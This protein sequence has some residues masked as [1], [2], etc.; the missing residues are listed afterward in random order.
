MHLLNAQLQI[1]KRSAFLQSHLHLPIQPLNPSI[2]TSRRLLLCK[3]VFA[4]SFQVITTMSKDLAIDDPG[5]NGSSGS[6]IFRWESASGLGKIQS[7][8]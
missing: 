3:F 1:V 2:D 7:G 6:S 5:M 4:P 8:T